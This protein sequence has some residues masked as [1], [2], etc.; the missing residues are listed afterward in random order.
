MMMNFD[1][2]LDVIQ[3]GWSDLQEKK[4]HPP[5][6]ARPA[7][8]SEPANLERNGECATEKE[9]FFEMYERDA[10]ASFFQFRQA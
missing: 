6:R 1:V 4:A 3:T 8:W 5:M 2:F 9:K 10:E 7:P